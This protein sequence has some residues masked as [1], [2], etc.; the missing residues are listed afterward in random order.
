MAL[1][2]A[3]MML[4]VI[5]V[6]GLTALRLSTAQERMTGYILDRQLAFQAAEAALREIEGRVENERPEAGTACTASATAAVESLRVCPL[7]RD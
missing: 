1:I 7:G 3:L 5:L 4:V 6:L 2:V